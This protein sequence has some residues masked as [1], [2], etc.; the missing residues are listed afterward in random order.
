MS[1]PSQYSLAGR[2]PAGIVFVIGLHVAFILAL[3][4]GLKIRTL[5]DTPTRMAAVVLLR[6][7]VK[8]VEPLVPENPTRPLVIGEQ[9]IEPVRLPPDDPVVSEL[10]T[11]PGPAETLL[12]PQPSYYA[13]VIADPAIDPH[14]PLSQPPYPPAAIRDGIQGN[15]ALDVL[16]GSDGH[17]RDARVVRSSGS[18]LLDRSAV[19][20]ARRHWKLRPATRDGVPFE[21]WYT[22]KVVFNLQNR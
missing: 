4:A 16:V 22:L 10:A 14:S 11:Q 19:D 2:N 3:A 6:E 7:P 8:S 20:E 17:V 1:Y 9:K 13:P 15:L 21:K 12:P 5:I 18:A